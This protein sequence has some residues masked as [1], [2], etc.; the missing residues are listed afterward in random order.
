MF[1]DLYEAFNDI[2]NEADWID[3][4]TRVA[5]VKKAEQ[6]I[7][8]LGYP[9]YAEDPEM[10]DDFYDDLRTCTWDHFGNSQGTRQF[11]LNN[12]FELI[13]KPRARDV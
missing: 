11:R 8:L 13:G 6:M 2:L 10:L 12:N 5:A 1:S 9:D 4:E 3:D 7:V